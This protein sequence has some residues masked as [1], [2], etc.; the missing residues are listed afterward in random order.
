MTDT[1]DIIDYIK[2]PALLLVT[3]KQA[4]KARDKLFFQGAD[5]LLKS[6]EKKDSIFFKSRFN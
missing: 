1:A 4:E 5:V 2:A 6:R 3:L